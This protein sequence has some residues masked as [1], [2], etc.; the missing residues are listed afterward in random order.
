MV[1]ELIFI[2][3][4]EWSAEDCLKRITG[5]IKIEE[6]LKARQRKKF[7]TQPEEAVGLTDY[8]RSIHQNCPGRYFSYLWKSVRES[9]PCFI[10][11]PKFGI[12][13]AKSNLVYWWYKLSPT[14]FTQIFTSLGLCMNNRN[15]NQK[16]KSETKKIALF[17][18]C[19]H[20]KLK[21]ITGKFFKVLSS[22]KLLNWK[23]WISESHGRFRTYHNK[24]MQSVSASEEEMLH[25]SSRP[26]DLSPRT[27]RR[28][29]GS[30][31]RPAGPKHHSICVIVKVQFS[32]RVHFHWYF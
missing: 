21:Q 7:T 19:Y 27:I 15:P 29:S 8:S 18:L 14:I 11:S 22:T 20:P 24:C 25:L 2:C 32:V 12:V 17:M 3:S 1:K 13:S 10:Y 16:D 30:I 6:I 26:I 28:V 31:Q 9:N 23:R 5:E 4:L